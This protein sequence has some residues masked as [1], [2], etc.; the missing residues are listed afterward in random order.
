MHMRPL[1][2]KHP[3]R[4][5]PRVSVIIPVH[6]RADLI[7]ETLQSV[8]AQ[9]YRDFEVLV[10]DDGSTDR[11]PQI[12]AEFLPH[13]R[14]I[15][16]AHAGQG[17]AT[18]RNAGIRAA[19]GEFIAFLDSDDL[20]FPQKLE[21]Q[22]ALFQRVPE[23]AWSYTDMEAFD[24]ATGATLYRQSSSRRLYEGDILV[25]LFLQMFVPLVTIMVRREVFDAVGEFFPS[26]KGTDYDMLLRIAA[27]HPIGLAAEVLTR[28]RVHSHSVT[29]AMTG[30]T[31]YQSIQPILARA[32]ARDPARLNP[33]LPQALSNTARQAAFLS[34]RGG[35]VREARQL[36]REAIRHTPYNSRLYVYYAATLAGPRVT[37]RLGVWRRRARA[38]L[39]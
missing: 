11:T 19:T 39:P 1:V 8:A 27:Q 7:R 23:L 25:P 38:L 13:I 10:V 16:Q 29:N 24:S 2:H 32:A 3:I 18:A 12:L 31:A 37:Y 36:L 28:Y 34:A 30:T 4:T 17:G 22:V 33:L 26:P 6:N 9:T 20:W 14:I 15:T 35:H 21:R 5:M